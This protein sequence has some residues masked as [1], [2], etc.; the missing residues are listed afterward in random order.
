MLN[1]AGQE[2]VPAGRRPPRRLAEAG[3][4]FLAGGAAAAATAEVEAPARLGTGA[5][6]N[7]PGGPE[8]ILLRDK[9]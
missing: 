6:A 7:R 8:E 4:L 9:K 2:G 3:A 1:Q 5:A